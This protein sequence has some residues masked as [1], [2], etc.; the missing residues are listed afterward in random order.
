MI[1]DDDETRAFE[2]ARYMSWVRSIA[3]IAQAL[4]LWVDDSGVLLQGVSHSALQKRLGIEKLVP[5]MTL[6]QLIPPLSD[7]LHQGL[8]LCRHTRLTQVLNETID[9]PKSILLL[10]IVITCHEYDSYAISIKDAHHERT[11]ALKVDSLASDQRQTVALLREMD[12]RYRT[13][14]DSLCEGV[15][16]VSKEGK[17]LAANESAAQIFRTTVPELIALRMD[18]PLPF[19][20][21]SEDLQTLP[22]E[23]WPSN[24]TLRTGQPRTGT[25]VGIVFPSGV[26]VWLEV[27]SRPLWRSGEGDPYAIVLSFFD[28]TLRKELEHEL[29]RRAFHDPLTSLPNRSL[30]VDRLDIAIRQARR[31]G[32]LVAVFF[33]DLDGFK[34]INDAHGHEVG[35][36]F[37]Q[38]I[39]N[40]LSASLRDG[41]TVARF[42]GDEF[43]VL[44]PAISASEDA[45]RVAERILGDLADPVTLDDLS[46]KASASLGI[47]VYPHDGQESA[48]LL[49]NA[50]QAM[51]RVKANG[52]NGCQF[53][54]E[55]YDPKNTQR[56]KGTSAEESIEQELR[57]ADFRFLFWPIV[58]LSSDH[59]VGFFVDSYQ[60]SIL[61]KPESRSD[62]QETQL[63]R[64]M[65][66]QASRELRQNSLE[67]NFPQL[68]LRIDERLLQ[69]RA[70]V[71]M[72]QDLKK[73]G[74]I[75]LSTWEIDIA[76]HSCS[77][78]NTNLWNSV[79]SL[80]R[81][82]VQLSLSFSPEA[83]LPLLQLANLPLRSVS[84][85]E[86]LWRRTAED[87]RALAM[88][89]GVVMLARRFNLLVTA[90]GLR[91]QAERQLAHELGCH[92]GQGS[93]WPS[94]PHLPN[95]RRP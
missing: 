73:R 47:S 76:L 36:R 59:C 41:D 33:L 32:D 86:S 45:L 52:R 34:E 16:F 8:S 55:E 79:E 22:Q 15:A 14:F 51:Y 50:D 75:P 68:V 26:P 31:T 38:M 90:T 1:S 21:I 70:A 37:L 29:Q 43:T 12:V 65:V 84:L 63:L 56:V 27:N 11:L 20:V 93:L 40:K 49:R 82:G 66:E 3:E 46:L 85:P 35:D 94:V 67:T 17:L 88:C 81:L 39:A 57:T 78:D 19:R 23:H 80:H 42:G 24:I 64:H 92:R 5:G 60:P 30:F 95:I 61:T 4:F 62:H 89:E 28:I 83:G 87:K 69:T 10:K 54:R 74:D 77:A 44:L 48:T 13:L 6:T 7:T 53:F 25:V 2:I 71:S 72:L 9:N 18:E 91:N 58:D